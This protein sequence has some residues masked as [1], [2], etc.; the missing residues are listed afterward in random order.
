LTPA[1]AVRSRDY[2]L[3]NLVTLYLNYGDG[4]RAVT[5]A[6]QLE[7]S[8]DQNLAQIARASQAMVTG[9]ETDDMTA[10]TGS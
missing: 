3:L 6:E 4:D 5:Y 2:A 9:S 10:S 1:A 8:Q 7:A